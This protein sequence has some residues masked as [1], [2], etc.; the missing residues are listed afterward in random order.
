MK[1]KKKYGNSDGSILRDDDRITA[2]QIAF[3]R[4]CTYSH[5]VCERNSLFGWKTNGEKQLEAKCFSVR[6]DMVRKQDQ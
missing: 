6:K 2:V 5:S 3:R 4:I 1:A